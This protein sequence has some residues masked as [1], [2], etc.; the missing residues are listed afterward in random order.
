MADNVL[1]D[2]EQQELLK[3]FEKVENGSYCGGEL[4]DCITAIEKLE[5]VYK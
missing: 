2:A 1:S 3:E 4:K 5:S